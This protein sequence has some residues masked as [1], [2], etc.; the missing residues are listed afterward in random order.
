MKS[1][2]VLVLAITTIQCS[3]SHASGQAIK[4]TSDKPVI[5]CGLKTS[6]GTTFGHL[7]V[8]PGETMIVGDGAMPV[9]G[10]GFYQAVE[11]DY[12]FIRTDFKYRSA[13]FEG[14]LVGLR[15]DRIRWDQQGRTV[16]VAGL[17][18]FLEAK[19]NIAI[20]SNVQKPKIRNGNLYITLEGR[21]EQEYWVAMR[22]GQIVGIG[23]PAAED[24]KPPAACPSEGYKKV[25]D[26]ENLSLSVSWSH[27]R[28]TE[29]GTV[30]GTVD[31]MSAKTKDGESVDIELSSSAFSHGRFETKD[32]GVIE[33]SLDG[34][35]LCLYA[36]NAQIKEL[37]ERLKSNK[38]QTRD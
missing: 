4:N 16:A 11:G 14:R 12:I 35:Y 2:S 9:Y 29:W 34:A 10:A 32:F 28:Y 31:R 23:K 26:V 37:R 1:L 22:F 15:V 6:K 18:S 13:L 25:W 7:Y 36:T 33:S 19:E 20:T 3:M 38:S 17:R 24:E 27:L 8:M 21:G 30:S 5:L